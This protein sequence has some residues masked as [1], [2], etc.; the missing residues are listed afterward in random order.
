[1]YSI[2]FTKQAAKDITRIPKNQSINIIDRIKKLADNPYSKELDVKK[3]NG[4]EG[5]RLRVGTYRVIYEIH[6]K[7][8][9]VSVIKIQSR[10]NV[11]G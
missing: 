9:I 5:Y 3:L 4:I 8:L 2:E 6:N 7:K 11:Y 10:G 1:M